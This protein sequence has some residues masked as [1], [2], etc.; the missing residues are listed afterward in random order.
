MN[1]IN[2]NLQYL[3]GL[4]NQSKL[5]END[6]ISKL[7]CSK[8]VHNLLNA[9]QIYSIRDLL[10]FNGSIPNVDISKLKE[11]NNLGKEAENEVIITSHNWLNR[12]CHLV[13]ANKQVIRVVI[14]HIVIGPHSVKIVVKWVKNGI[15]RQ[16]LVT[17]VSLICTQSFWLSYDIV[18]EDSESESESDNDT[19]VISVLPK[20][21]ID[22]LNH[23]VKNLNI[24]QKKALK[25]IV[26]E[27]NQLFNCIF[28]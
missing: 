20:L 12:K 21:K 22:I 13:R 9:N 19:H 28:N 23:N 17:P 14:G 7:N 26:K 8:T 15:K 27:T 11:Q 16:R 25:S 1:E 5:N 10:H 18:S 4:K 3:D 6:D 2:K 24:Y